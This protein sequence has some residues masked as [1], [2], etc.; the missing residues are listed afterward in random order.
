VG[1]ETG[2]HPES[3]EFIGYLKKLK[4]FI[5]GF[6]LPRMR[7]DPGVIV[8]G[9]PA[10][11]VSRALSEPGNQYG[12]YVHHST[13]TRGRNRYEVSEQN[14]TIDLTLDLPAG[15]WR[16]DW[17]RSADLAVLKSQTI[18]RHR[19]GKVML[20]A[21]PEHQADIALKIVKR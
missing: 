5:T 20:A 1:N 14:R 9:V 13:A 4:E 17:L 6:N 7:P 8:S 15:A 12:I 19:G 2:T 10:G 16:V 18:T 21:S 3:D 11:S